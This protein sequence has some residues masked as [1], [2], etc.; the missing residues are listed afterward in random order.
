LS[1]IRNSLLNLLH[2]TDGI[3]IAA[4]LRRHAAHPREALKLLR[5]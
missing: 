2:R 1:I 5:E 3:N 4:T